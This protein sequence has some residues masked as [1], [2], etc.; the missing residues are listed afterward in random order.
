MQ[1]C[2]TILQT[3]FWGD[4]FGVVEIAI[5]HILTHNW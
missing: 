2:I 3:L 5:S 1:T 4:I